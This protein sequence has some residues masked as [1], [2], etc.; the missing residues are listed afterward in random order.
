MNRNGI[1]VHSE[2]LADAFTMA[3]HT[4]FHTD[5]ASN[6]PSFILA[7]GHEI[8]CDIAALRMSV[9][10]GYYPIV[11]LMKFADLNQSDRSN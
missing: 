7:I 4:I 5:M 11:K 8:S 6:D 2:S 3:L 1:P 9:Y 10:L